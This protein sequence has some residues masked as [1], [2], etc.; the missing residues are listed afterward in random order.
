MWLRW[1]PRKGRF[2]GV[3]VDGEGSGIEDIS[4]NQQGMAL[5]YSENDRQL[6]LLMII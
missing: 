5:N 1:H 2:L 3:G 6:H 4:E